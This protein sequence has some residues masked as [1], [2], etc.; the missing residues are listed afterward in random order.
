MLLTGD[1]IRTDSVTMADT[2][3]VLLPAKGQGA[4]TIRPFY[5]EGPFAGT[6]YFHL[7]RGNGQQGV[8]GE[9][10]PYLV[11][12]DN[13]VT[14]GLLC[15]F[16]IG[17]VALSGSR[18]FIL[19]QAKNFFHMPRRVADGGVPVGSIRLQYLLM[20]QVSLVLTLGSFLFGSQLGI[21]DG[22]ATGRW[23]LL[24]AFF[25]AF[26]AYFLLKGIL[27]TAVNWVFFERKKNEQWWH[28]WLFLTTAEGVLLFPLLLLAVYFDV[29]F[30]YS[31]YYTLFVVISVKILSFYKCF[32]IFFKKAAFCLQNILYFCA[33]EL[34]PVAALFGVLALADNVLYINY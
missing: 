24:G 7:C 13:V 14:I 1:S 6:P 22:T 23:L 32:R 31:L 25:A 33:L 10:V 29:S 5:E 20:L 8:A 9:T 28:T 4:L 27:Y 12:R 18:E 17:L 30:I 21:L 26:V 19:R 16:I 15:T 34:M 2:T 3:S 11:S